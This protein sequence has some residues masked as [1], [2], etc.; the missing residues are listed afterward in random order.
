MLV[1]KHEIFWVYTYTLSLA[2]S[3]LLF[4]Y[5]GFCSLLFAGSFG[6]RSSS[7]SL[8]ELSRVSNVSETQRY[9]SGLSANPTTD[10]DVAVPLYTFST[11][12]PYWEK[13][14]QETVRIPES[15]LCKDEPGREDCSVMGA[16]D[17]S[18]SAWYYEIQFYLGAAGT[19][20]PIHFHGHAINTLAYGEKVSQVP[21]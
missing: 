11:P 16:F 17:P 1:M 5:F 18:T 9:F 3:F 12:S 6:K 10:G 21:S 2:F 20:S 4:I 14:L 19:G 8:A 15:M 7:A 13:L